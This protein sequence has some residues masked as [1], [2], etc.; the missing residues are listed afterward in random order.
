MASAALWAQAPPAYSGHGATSV[1]PEIIEK[2]AP[3]PLP[4]EVTRPIQA[5]LDVR[6]PGLGLPSD[7]GRRLFLTWSVTGVN[8]VWRLDAPRSFPVQLTGGEDATTVA[9]IT[10]D[11]K[12]LILS[13]DRKGEEN[14]GLYLQSPEGGALRTIQHL[15]G[16]QTF[17]EFATDDSR[18]I[19]YSANDR[20][21]A[22][23]A[24]YRYKLADG[25]KELVHGEPGLWSVAGHRD[26]K[27]LLKRATG[28]LTSEYFELN[29][30]DRKLVPR[31]GQNESEE[32]EATYAAAPGELLVQTPKFGEFRRLYRFA[33]GKFLPVTPE[34]GWDVDGFLIDEGRTRLLYS[35]NEAG[36]SRL[37]ALDAKTYAPIALPKFTGADHVTDGAFSRSGRYVTLGVEMATA[38]RQSYLY[39]FAS[40]DLVPW[41]VPS[42]PEVDTSGFVKPVL[43][44]YPARDGTKI[45]LFV[46]RPAK[47][48]EGPCPVVIEFHGGP[49]GQSQPAFSTRAQ[50]FV[51]AGFVHLLPNVRGSDG[52]GKSW[53]AADNGAKRL[54][55]ITDIE[56]AAIYARKAFAAGGKEPKVGIYGG[57]YGGYSSLIG[58][59]MFAGAYDA[60]V[61]IV[62]IS[63]LRT[64][65]LNTAP[66]RRIL[67]ASE[68]GDP[69]KDKEAL[70]KLSPMTYI[71]RLK[72]PLLLIQ[73]VSDPRVPVGEA[74]QIHDTLQKK[75]VPS[76]LVLFAD[77]GHGA[78]RRDNVAIQTATTLEFFKKHLQWR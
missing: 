32:Y 19:Y 50:L 43:E 65:L 34:L 53:L 62:G 72:A 11:E 66:Y 12:W 67:R 68:Y 33:G 75:G 29:L 35:V 54:A 1:T 20:E 49:E 44:E 41:T 15:A 10:P 74:L 73:G 76:E 64:F 7:D 24:L 59:T 17:F 70:A 57:S 4:G 48:C 28:A 25:T 52:Y 9:G 60:G 30:G 55:I 13:R 16:V 58:M 63:D 14:P 78:R 18:W 23:Y 21:R 56:D 40:G 61:S 46:R 47:P 77:E 26:G 36:Y 45:P 37:S 27:L 38:P 31:L 51:E 42:A 8:Q 6:A 2:F 22:S 5:Y 71:D 3:K 39:D 69:E